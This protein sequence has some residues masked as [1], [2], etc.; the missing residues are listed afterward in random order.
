MTTYAE[1]IGD[2][3]RKIGVLSEGQEA[4]PEQGADGLVTFNEM[5]GE[6]A[7]DGVDVGFAP[8]S[9]GTGTLLIP[10][11]DRQ[12]IKY[13]LCVKLATDYGREITPDI[14]DGYQEGMARLLR[15]AVIANRVNCKLGLPLGEGQRNRGNI[16]NDA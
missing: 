4:S 12:A 2:A 13:A 3:L 16:L 15:K 10:W 14:A 11:E 1:F 5:M 6:L 7:G 8:Q 9:S